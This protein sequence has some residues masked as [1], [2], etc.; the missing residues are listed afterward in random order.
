L[1]AQ[2]ATVEE[3]GRIDIVVANAGTLNKFDKRES[4]NLH[5]YDLW[6]VKSVL[7][8]CVAF[9]EKDPDEWWYSVE[10]NLRGE[11]NTV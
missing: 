10:V 9:A 6:N 3:F 4:S 1:R 8:T 5:V 2:F 7:A 11:F